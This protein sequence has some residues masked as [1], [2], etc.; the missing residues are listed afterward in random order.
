VR[1]T[2]PTVAWNNRL[3]KQIQRNVGCVL[4]TIKLQRNQQPYK[5]PMT[6]NTNER[7]RVL[8]ERSAYQDRTIDAL[9]EVIIAQQEQLDRLE[10]QVRRLQ[11]Y[12]ANLSD[13]VPGTVDPPPPHY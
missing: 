3:L 4:R 6:E 10:E 8:E 11:N 13:A 2:H 1:G 12:L 5:K 7:I 9:N